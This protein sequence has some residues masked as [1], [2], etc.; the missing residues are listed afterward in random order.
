MIVLEKDDER[1][2]SGAEVRIETLVK[3]LDKTESRLDSVS[4]RLKEVVRLE[5]GHEHLLD[6]TRELTAF[7][8]QER[9]ERRS[10]LGRVFDRIEALEKETGINTFSRAGIH[11]LIVPLVV[12]AF[13]S[14]L[15]AGL[16]VWLTKAFL[17]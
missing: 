13:S 10:S 11:D 3:N 6:L 9:T 12:S 5:K 7:I 16:A 2:L 14:V 4:E 15:S 8:R 17:V 1:R